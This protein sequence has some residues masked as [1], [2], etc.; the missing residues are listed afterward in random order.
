MLSSAA[1]AL[2][3]KQFIDFV[4]NRVGNFLRTYTV[5]LQNDAKRMQ[6]FALDNCAQT[7][8]NKGK[9]LETQ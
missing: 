1:T 5:K 8:E 7:I 3:V 4:V 6:Y 2:S 9:S